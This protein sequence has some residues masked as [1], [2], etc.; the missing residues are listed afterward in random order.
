MKKYDQF[1]QNR[2]GPGR[3][4]ENTRAS[5]QIQKGSEKT[6]KNPKG[7]DKNQET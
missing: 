7:F 2:G 5:T 6:R 4:A 3:I 1:P